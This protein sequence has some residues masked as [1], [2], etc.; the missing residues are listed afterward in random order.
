[1]RRL[2]WLAAL[3]P[4]VATIAACGGEERLSLEEALRLMVLQPEDLP[5]FEVREE[6][7]TTNEDAA[8]GSADRLALLDEWGRLLGYE[9]AYEPVDQTLVAYPVDGINVSASIYLTEEGASDSFAD[10]VRT[11]KETDWAATYPGLREFMREEITVSELADEAIWLRLTGRETVGGSETLVTDDLIFFRVGP[12]R[13]F[14]RVLARSIEEDS[15]EELRE[16]VREWLEALVRN[17]EAA[18][19]DSRFRIEE[20]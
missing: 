5:G 20:G 7:F 10:A 1:M 12:E 17:V 15:R 13:G 11:A 19:A 8:G 6:T 14:M 9:V 2:L 4:V 3:L 18:L 16:Q